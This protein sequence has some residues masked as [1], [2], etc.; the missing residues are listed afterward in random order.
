MKI[1]F[2]S[3]DWSQSVFDDRG[4]PVWG[5]SGWAR[6]GQYQN[7]VP[8]N[9]VV[10]ALCSKKGVFGVIDWDKNPHFDLDVIL[11]QR[12]MFDD[13][14]DK[15][16]PAIAAGQKII[17]DVDDWYWGLSQSNQAWQ[18]SHPK[19]NPT[20]N[21]DHYRKIVEWSSGVIA[22]TPYLAT[23]LK[24]FVRCP[25]VTIG[26]YI[27]TDRF[28]QHNHVDDVPTVGWVGSTSH[29]SNDL[30]ILRT[31]LP[32]LV[33]SGKI[34]LQ[35]S[36]HLRGAATFASAVGV[37]DELVATMPMAAPKDYPSLLNFDIGLV[38]LNDIPFNQAKSYIKGLE[39]AAAGIPFIASNLDEY[40]RLSDQYNI[41]RTAKKANHWRAAIQQLSDPAIRQQEAAKNLDNLRPL[42]IH[43]GAA[44][45]TEYLESFV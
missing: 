22:S 3:A 21:R 39:Y 25:V 18:A 31:V 11:M 16:R 6:L 44:L 36:G 5:G 14:A 8:H 24:E 15:I 27:D 43:I 4:H 38:P 41:G 29:R 12:V 23:K 17:N 13:V 32:Q 45:L 26:N 19:Y 10:G 42:D 7:I 20:E 1:G 9:V 40:R 35:H 34:K 37:P 28:T 2:A 33:K 30:E